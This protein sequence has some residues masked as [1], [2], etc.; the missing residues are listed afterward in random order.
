[1]NRVNGS[2]DTASG[3]GAFESFFGGKDDFVDFTKV[4]PREFGI[5]DT[6]IC[7]L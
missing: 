6:S 3:V 1:M 5:D 7:K 2:R 4:L